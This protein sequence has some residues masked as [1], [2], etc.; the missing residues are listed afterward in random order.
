MTSFICRTQNLA[1]DTCNMG[2]KYTALRGIDESALKLH[3][4][5]VTSLLECMEPGWIRLSPGAPAEH[6][7][8]QSNPEEQTDLLKPKGGHM[9]DTGKE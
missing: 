2:T 7:L 5:T 3:V 6:Q 1:A 9:S 4:G 8:H